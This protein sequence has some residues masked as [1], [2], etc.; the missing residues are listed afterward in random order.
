MVGGTGLYIKAFCE[1]LDKIPAIDP[2]IRK[3]IIDNYTK[4]GLEWLQLEIANKD[5]V[6]AQSGEMKNPQRM[7]R[8]LEVIASTG[9]SILSFRNGHRQKRNFN[10]L[11]IGLELPKPVLDENIEHRV[12]QMMTEGLLE[13]VRGLLPFQ[14]LNALQTVGYT[15]C[16][17]YLNGRIDLPE[18]IKRIKINTRQYAKRQLTWFRK[19]KMI[20]WF[21]PGQVEEMIQF[22]NGKPLSVNE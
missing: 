11:K 13:E 21:R 3:Q 22:I 10:V 19:D 18:A 15:E 14:E 7:M 4:K 2:E 12:D 1:G 8:A 5:S 17:D 9:K 16:F 6:Y 20:N